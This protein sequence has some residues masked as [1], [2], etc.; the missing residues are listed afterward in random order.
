M[1]YRISRASGRDGQTPDQLLT[2]QEAA[3]RLGL[4]ATTL[5]AWRL[6]RAHLPFVTLGGAVRIPSDAVEKFIRENTVPARGVAE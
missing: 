5:R 6:R 3:A 1:D 4:K 2:I